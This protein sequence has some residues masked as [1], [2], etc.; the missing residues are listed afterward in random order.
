MKIEDLTKIIQKIAEQ[1]IKMKN[2][3]LEEK[4]LP[5]DYVTIFAHSDEEFEQLQEVAQQM[6]KQV[7]YN[8]GPAYRL[9][10]SIDIPTGKLRYF[11]IRHPDTERPQLGCGDFIVK[12]YT[13][14]KTKYLDKDPEHLGL[15]VREEYEMFEI[16]DKDFDVLAYIPSIRFSEFLDSK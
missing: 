5:I 7:H 8:N 16:K 2:Q 10:E 14:F 4:D 15:I 1:I 6:G 3:H 9:N 11:R 12:D 13:A